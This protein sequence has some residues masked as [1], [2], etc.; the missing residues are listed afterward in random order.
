MDP[1]AWEDFNKDR[2]RTMAQER[3]D[4]EHFRGTRSPVGRRHRRRIRSTESDSDWLILSVMGKL[5]GT[6]RHR[7]SLVNHELQLEMK[8]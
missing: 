2:A 7:K 1:Q 6:A 5:P 8:D 3:A 4:A